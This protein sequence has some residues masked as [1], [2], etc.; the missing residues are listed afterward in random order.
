[1]GRTILKKIYFGFGNKKY[2]LIVS[3]SIAIGFYCYQDYLLFKKI[4]VFTG[5]ASDTIRQ[6][7][8]DYYFR[9]ERLF[10]GN[11][12]FWSFQ[13]D[14]GMNVYP[15]IANFNP[16]DVITI[17]CGREHLAYAIPYIVL[18]KIVLTGLIFFAFLKKLN[19]SDYPAAA[20]SL[21]FSFCGYVTINSHWY[22]YLNY[23][24]F[25]SLMLFLFERWF[26]DGKWL[27]MVLAIGFACIKGVLQLYQFIFFLALY[28]LFRIVYENGFHLKEILIFYPKLYT[29]YGIGIGLGAFYILPELYQAT[30]SA[31][32]GESIQ[33]FALVQWILDAFKLNDPVTIRTF[34]FRYLSNDI[35]GSFE[36]FRG[37]GNYLEAPSSYSGLIA[38]FITPIVFINQ[39]SR[40]KIAFMLFVS[41]MLLYFLFPYIRVIG[42]AFAS[43]TYKHTIMYNSIILIIMASFAIDRLVTDHVDRIGNIFIS[44]AFFFGIWVIGWTVKELRIENDVLHKVGLFMIFYGVI[45]SA[46]YFPKVNTIAKYALFAVVI[47][48]LAVFS[49][50][51]VSRSSGPLT[52]GFI[53]RGERYF[54]KDTLNALEFIKATDHTFYRTEKGYVSDYLNDAVVQKYYGTSA[55]YG[56]SAIGVV[57]FHKSMKISPQSPRIASYRY[58]LSKRDKLQS[59]LCVKYYLSKKMDDMPYGFDYVRSFGTVHLFQ[60]RKSMPLGIAYHRHIQRN[61]FEQLPVETKEGVL[62]KAF[63]SDKE[64]EDMERIIPSPSMFLEKNDYTMDQQS[65]GFEISSFK[66]N[67]IKGK[68]HLKNEGMLFF[69][70]PFDKGWTAIVDGKEKKPDLINIAFMGLNL[71]QGEHDIELRFVPPY[72]YHGIVISFLTTILVIIL[73]T[74]FPNIRA[75]EIHSKVKPL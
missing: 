18:L 29:L 68:I 59:L 66:E 34:L 63:V 38:L 51:T 26:Q 5:F 50:I 11:F 36:R 72:L 13:H 42:N 75:T 73:Y 23:A 39:N 67:V 69:S 3:L 31:R 2:I 41:A 56:F 71:K 25:A 20:G 74:R 8:A 53:E 64:Y 52:P 15:V 40:R 49:R 22:H 28:G 32:G 45:F 35:L 43:G 14:L 19:I 37:A 55:Y 6:F 65:E 30:S 62:L 44:F 21:L 17:L 48:E 47:I 58:G 46:F 4:F 54:D 57:D 61:D 7:F 1:M 33:K 10:S 16:F 60:N 24:L 27:L 70:I 9:S 12:S